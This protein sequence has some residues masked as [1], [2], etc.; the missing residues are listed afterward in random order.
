MY[1]SRGYRPP[2]NYTLRRLVA[3]T[4]LLL[5]LWLLWTLIGAVTGR[6]GDDGDETVESGDEE[7]TSTTAE[8]DLLVA[9]PPCTYEDQP[10]TYAQPQDWARTLVDIVHALPADYEPPD[11]VSGA[12]AGYQAD[13][14]IRDLMAVDLDTMRNAIFEAPGVD[15]AAIESGYRSIENQTQIFEA[16][17]AANGFEETA[18]GTARGGHSEHHLG[19]AID[20]REFNTDTVSET[21]AETST[22][23]WLVDNSWQYGFILSYPAGKEAVTCRKFEPWHFRYVGRDLAARVNETGLTLR[24]YLWHWEKTGEEPTL[25]MAQASATTSSTSSPSSTSFG[26]TSSTVTDTSADEGSA[27]TG[28][29]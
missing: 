18:R 11:L 5:V 17:E 25:E 20:F 16:R 8:V 15:E 21:F 27:D 3:L 6:G 24:E 23:E 4:G 26:D 28:A 7:T 9:P 12:A 1:P 14:E 19:T 13:I 10:T 22:Y 2:P 29:G